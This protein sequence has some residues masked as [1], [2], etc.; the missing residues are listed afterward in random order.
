MQMTTTYGKVIFNDV[1][2]L[3]IVKIRLIDAV[4]YLLIDSWILA[5]IIRNMILKYKEQRTNIL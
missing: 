1:E 4:N 2:C 5:Y 3:I